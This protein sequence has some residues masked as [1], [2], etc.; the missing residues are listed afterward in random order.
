MTGNRRIPRAVYL[1]VLPAVLL[2]F[3]FHTVPVL[4]GIFYAFTDS[5]GY[6]TWDFVGWSNF[7]A[8]F[9]DQRILDSYWFTA[10]FAI[11]ATVLVNV[12]ALAIAVGLNGRIKFRNTLRGIY[13]LPNVLAILIVGYVFQYLFTNSLPAIGQ[14]LGVDALSSSLLAD[15]DK[16]WIGILVLA[17]WQAVAFNIILYLAGLQTVPPELYEAAALDGAGSWR[18]FRSITFPMIAGFFTINVVLSL[19]GFLQVF[20]HIIAMTGGGPGTATESVSVVIYKGGF[21]GGEYGYQV[22]NSVIF[23][24]VIVAFAV[25][26]LRILQ[27][28]EVS[29]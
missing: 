1:M 2:F 11:A 10:K 13:F 14:A 26:Q 25:F 9:G 20:D 5:P 8:L 17:V 28:R 23:M 29:L 12:I 19:K 22:A 15:A 7:V 24:I 3:T 4:Q 18:K 27:R 21:Q 6:G 16:A